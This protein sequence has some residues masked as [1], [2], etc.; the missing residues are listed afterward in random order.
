[1][2]ENSPQFS[3]DNLPDN[4]DRT[5][6]WVP[7]WLTAMRPLQIHLV[8]YLFSNGL[9]LFLGLWTPLL[10]IVWGLVLLAHYLAFKTGSVDE[11]W[12]EAWM[13]RIRRQSY[14]HRHI[15]DIVEST[16]HDNKDDPAAPRRE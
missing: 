14:D 15:T 4:T 6:N 1:M 8:V 11:Q 12:G 13:N 16:E 10:P 3:P 9:A 2:A 5:A 7:A